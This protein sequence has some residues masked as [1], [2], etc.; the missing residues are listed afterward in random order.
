[1]NSWVWKKVAWFLAFVALACAPAFI[2]HAQVTRESLSAGEPAIASSGNVAAGVTTA[3]LAA[4]TG[5]GVSPTPTWYVTGFEITGGGATAGSIIACTITGL[6]GG[7]ATYNYAV[8]TGVAVVS[9]SFVMNFPGGVAGN[10]GTAI[11]F[12]CPSFGAGNTNSALDIRGV[13]VR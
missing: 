3:T 10:P 2:A 6:V 1:M 4:P 11:V 7:T 5:S 13:L 8:P 9:P 12:S